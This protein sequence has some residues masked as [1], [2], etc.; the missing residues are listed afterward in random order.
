MELLLYK[1][2]QLDQLG[3]YD[4]IAF[5]DAPSDVKAS[6]RRQAEVAVA[7]VSPIRREEADRKTVRRVM[8]D[9][10]DWAFH[11][12]LGERDLRETDA[13]Q[14]TISDLGHSI[15]ITGTLQTW[16]RSFELELTSPLSMSEQ[17]QAVRVALQAVRR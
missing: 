10:R 13:I 16:I 8:Q 14:R 17:A 4:D 9:L 15:Q 5:L 12:T 1:A 7:S 6:I 11:R 3:A 2:W